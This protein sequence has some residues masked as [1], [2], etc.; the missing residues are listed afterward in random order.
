MRR[1]RTHCCLQ[2]AL[3]EIGSNVLTLSG[4]DGASFTI[5]NGN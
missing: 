1:D 4:T 5:V 2:S 3:G